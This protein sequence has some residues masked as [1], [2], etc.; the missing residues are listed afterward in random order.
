MAEYYAGESYLHRLDVRT[1]ILVF[2]AIMVLIFLFNDP[3][4]NAA[5]ALLIVALVAPS[6]VPLR[7]VAG[8]MKPL[9]AIFVLVIAMT[10]FTAPMSGFRTD[11]A[12]T[13]MF[14]LL[15]GNRVPATLGGL[16]IGTTYLLRI[17]IMVF[18]TTV[19]TLTTPIDDILQFM[20]KMKAPYEM[21]IIVSTAISFIPT[22]AAKKDMILQA[23]R[24]R[25]ARISGKGVFGQLK[26]YTPIMVPLII[27]SILLANNLS[28]AMLNRGY[29]ANKSWTELRDIRMSGRD[30]A[31]IAASIAL[32]GAGICLKAAWGL[33]TI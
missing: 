15:P 25:G 31:V 14:Y 9:I 2:V 10:C 19:F 5:L 26:A 7:G 6:R 33:G 12:R 20:G 4:Y 11:A 18:A 30:Y 23:Q 21:S 24:A 8:A 13:V 17:F 27:N 32:V 28:V 3:L 16:M 29:G 22:M 1:K